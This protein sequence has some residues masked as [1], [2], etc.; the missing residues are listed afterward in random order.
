MDDK[1]QNLS[2][3]ENIIEKNKWIFAKTYANTHPHQYIVKSRCSGEGDFDCLCEYIKKYGHFEYFFKKRGTYCSIGEFTYWNMGDIINRRWND[4]Y[5][6][7]DTK[8]IIKVDNWKE[9]LQDGR[10]LYK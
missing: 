4:M 8:Q 10:I 1:K 2:N 7:T 3:V 9:L 6:L 5:Q